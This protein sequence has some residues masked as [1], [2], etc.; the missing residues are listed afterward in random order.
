[1]ATPY[2]IA[3]FFP[4]FG[5]VV[6]WYH[7]SET[8]LN[9]RVRVTLAE[10][11][12]ALSVFFGIRAYLED[13]P[14]SSTEWHFFTNLQFWLSWR[15]WVN[16]TSPHF[17]LIMM[18]KP[19]NLIFL[20][21]IL[22]TIFGYWSEKPAVFKALLVVSG[23][24]A[25]PLFILFCYRDEFRNLSLMFPFLYLASVHSLHVLYGPRTV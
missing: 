12:L 23:A 9:R 3:I 11:A 19:S 21:P 4:A 17:P 8:P 7:D 13:H 1:M 5:A 15:P 25:L 24:I 20:L 10:F 2:G 22:A 18:P 6:R 16:I 14:G